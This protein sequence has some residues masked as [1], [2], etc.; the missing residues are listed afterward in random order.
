MIVDVSLVYLLVPLCSRGELGVLTH[1]LQ[2]IP[3]DCR[4]ELEVP[5]AAI[6]MVE[7]S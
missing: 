7:V 2:L 6:M 3:Y 5:S 4:G 1:T